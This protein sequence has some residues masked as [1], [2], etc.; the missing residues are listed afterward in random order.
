[1]I[2]KPALKKKLEEY[3]Q[4]VDKYPNYS[5]GYINLATV[6]SS[7]GNNKKAQ[8]ALDKAFELATNDS[9]RYLIFYNRAVMYYNNQDFKSALECARKAQK[10]KNDETTNTLLK[11][12][13]TMLSN[14]S[15]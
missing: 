3:Q 2:A 12:I 1:M 4:Y 13:E 9:E 11:D 15:K 7:M 5:G 10:I 6:Y 8:Q 14:I